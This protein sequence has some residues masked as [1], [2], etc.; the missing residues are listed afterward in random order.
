MTASLL[1]LTLAITPA[2]LASLVIQRIRLPWEKK[3]NPSER[4][5]LLSM[6]AKDVRQVKSIMA[7]NMIAVNAGRARSLP[8]LPLSNW[9]RLKK[10]LRL[11]KYAHD[12]VVK[13]MVRQFR[14]WERSAV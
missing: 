14:E 12:P 13:T 10:D 4:A 1:Q 5:E 2:I 3:L 6:L 8:L 9:K 7:K 11:K